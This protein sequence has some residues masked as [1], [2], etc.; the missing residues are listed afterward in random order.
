MAK[1]PAIHDE[2]YTPSH[3]PAGLWRQARNP[4]NL[5]S[6]EVCLLSP[7]LCSQKWYIFTSSQWEFLKK[8]RG[9]RKFAWI[10]PAD[11]THLSPSILVPFKDVHIV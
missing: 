9:E 11:A 4:L 1:V 5:Y 10:F 7:S 6:Y 3:N 8:F 2:S